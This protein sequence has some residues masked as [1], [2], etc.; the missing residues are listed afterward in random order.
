MT[1]VTLE[2][3][4]LDAGLRLR[5]ALLR[6]AELDQIID[7]CK[8]ILLEHLTAGETGQTPNGQ[9]VVTRKPG[10]LV[11]DEKAAQAA[12]PAELLLQL[13]TTET[14]IDRAKAKAILPPAVYALCCKQNSD[15]IV[16][17]S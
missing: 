2:D 6:R 4:I 5:E 9:P 8:A 16:V 14:K 11:W 12:L 13:Q 15:S 7:Q 10:A 1:T 17:A 3:A